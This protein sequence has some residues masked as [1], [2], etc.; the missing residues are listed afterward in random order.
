VINLLINP[1]GIED[2]YLKCLNTCFPAW[3]DR[4]SFDWYFRRQP[5]ADLIVF[6]AN[7]RTAAGSA[8]TYRRLILPNGKPVVA[9]IMTGSWTLPEFRRQGFF[10]RTIEASVKLARQR[11]AALLLA[12][13]TDDNS[14]F[15]SLASAGAA[16]VPTWY[17]FST[18]ETPR[19]EKTASYKPVQK[20]QEIVELIFSQFQEATKSHCRFGYTG[21]PEFESQF[22]DRPAGVT[23][24]IEGDDGSFAIVEVDRNTEQLLLLTRSGLTSDSMRIGWFLNRAIENNRQ[25]FLFSSDRAV[26]TAARQL[27]LESK[28]GH[29]TILLANTGELTSA[30]G[31]AGDPSSA[32]ALSQSEMPWFIG[33]WSI[34][35]GERA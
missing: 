23:H 30:L 35:G 20:D 8:I 7:G 10:A 13:V 11:R 2:E 28:A 27:G 24:A 14:S 32:I 6:K 33:P 18:K 34:A 17:L 1:P 16:L 22:F 29:V 21:L 26:A 4:R 5:A 31:V 12:F 25:C 3:G 15:R 19:V 9:G